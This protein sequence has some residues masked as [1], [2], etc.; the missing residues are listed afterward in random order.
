MCFVDPKR[1]IFVL[2]LQQQEDEEMLVPHSDLAENNHQP[3]DGIIVLFLLV[4]VLVQ[5]HYS[6]I[7]HV[8]LSLGMFDLVR[9]LEFEMF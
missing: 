1:M 4:S 3:M 6:L 8:L 5:F 9:F 2:S 7:L